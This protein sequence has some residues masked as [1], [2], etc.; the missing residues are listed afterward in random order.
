MALNQAPELPSSMNKRAQRRPS[1]TRAIA[2]PF[3]PE[4]Q[5]HPNLPSRKLTGTVEEQL[6]GLAKIC[7]KVL[8]GDR[9]W[10]L[11]TDRAEQWLLRELPGDKWAGMDNYDVDLSE[12]RSIKKDLIRLSRLT[13]VPTDCNLWMRVRTK[14]SLVHAVIRQ[15]KDWSQWYRFA[16]MTIEPMTD[17]RKALDGEQVMLKDPTSGLISV[18]AP[19]RNSRKE[20][21]GFVE[22]CH[23]REVVVVTQ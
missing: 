12:F 2:Q 17:M 21:V 16:Q 10:R 6:T 22:I 5:P 8:D 1:T 4:D 13:T 15:A 9:C 3:R 23:G 14:E 7:T 20:V 18:L 19:V 11:V